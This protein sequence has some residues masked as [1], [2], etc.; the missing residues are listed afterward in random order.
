M[1]TAVQGLAITLAPMAAAAALL[2]GSIAVHAEEANSFDG[3]WTV[4]WVNNSGSPTEA[5][6]EL[7]GSSGTF[8]QFKIQRGGKRDP[9]SMDAAPVSAER[10]GDELLV[11]VKYSEAVK[12]CLDSTIKLKKVSD[13][14]LEGTFG[15]GKQVSAVKE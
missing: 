5:A 1:K 11:T 2:L 8:K 10:S 7:N 6:M 9:C 12:G 13:R 14:A 3:K 4:K 15:G